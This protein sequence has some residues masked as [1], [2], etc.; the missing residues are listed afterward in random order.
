M[1]IENRTHQRK[2]TGGKE[3]R[4][5]QNDLKQDRMSFSKLKHR[6]TSYTHGMI[7]CP[8]LPGKFRFVF[9]ILS[10]LSIPNINAPP[11]VLAKALTLFS[12]DY[13]SFSS[14][15]TFFSYSVVSPIKSIIS[16]ILNFFIVSNYTISFLIMILLLRDTYIIFIVLFVLFRFNYF[17]KIYA[18]Y[19]ISSNVLS[20]SLIWKLRNSNIIV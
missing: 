6:T 2:K 15:V 3:C 1:H 13:G 14:S 7:L 5:D 12:Q 17:S 16:S 9:L 10:S 8:S 4:D 20:F 11:L 19:I 18:S